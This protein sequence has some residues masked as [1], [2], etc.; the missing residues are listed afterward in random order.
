MPDWCLLRCK[1][2]LEVG[3]LAGSALTDVSK[4]PQLH[5]QVELA[6]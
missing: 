4:Q 2:A 3:I 1:W 5:V 6:G